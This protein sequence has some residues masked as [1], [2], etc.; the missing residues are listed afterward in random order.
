MR[1][2]EL[3]RE[4]SIVTSEATATLPEAAEAGDGAG[5]RGLAP[6]AFMVAGLLAVGLAATVL[7]SA[8]NRSGVTSA[9]APVATPAAAD[10]LALTLS[11]RDVSIVHQ[12]YEPGEA[13]GWHSHSGI[14][15]VAV[16]SG[17]LTVY[18]GQCQARTFQA[19]QPYV[20][21]QQLHL[22]RNESAEPV[23]MTVTYL[24]PASGGEPTRK[25]PAP[26]GCAS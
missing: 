20:G 24:N 23:V 1:T 13:S 22:V 10:P 2:A 9:P 5:R 18:D 4:R 14:H 17:T 8:L 16:L 15:A 11:A 25:L 7:L 3:S 12:V 19:G 26:G 21:G 6:V